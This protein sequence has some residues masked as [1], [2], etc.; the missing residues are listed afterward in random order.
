MARPHP[1]FHADRPLVFAHRGGAALA[2]ENTLAAFDRGV[3]LGADGIELDLHRSRDGHL[4][5]CHDPTVDRTT[6]GRGRIADLDLA[7]LQTLDAGYRFTPDD[8]RTFP[9]R[10]Q[11]VRIPTFEE[12][13]LRYPDTRFSIE[14]KLGDLVSARQ[15]LATAESAGVVG[16]TCLGAFNQKP[17]SWLRSRRRGVA[18]WATRPEV[19]RFLA[20]D[21]LRLSRVR[22]PRAHAFC[23][24]EHSGRS[25]IVTPRRIRALARHGTPVHVW[26]VDDQADMRRLL[27][28]GVTGLVTDRPDLAVA[29]VSE[30]APGSGP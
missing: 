15:A 11:D 20:L 19:V 13:L 23:I 2:P 16:R 6:D 25:R 18:T 4:V 3:A 28:W 27:A 24:P 12:I 7:E 8:G 1:F 10:G 26:T 30:R 22:A 14:L 29:A 21:A 9:F 5:A 17:V